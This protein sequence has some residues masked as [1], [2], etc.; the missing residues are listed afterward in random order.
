MR[1]E[2][3]EMLKFQIKKGLHIAPG[4]SY[5]S[6]PAFNQFLAEALYFKEFKLIEEIIEKHSNELEPGIRND[7]RNWGLASLFFERREY[8]KALS[9]AHK[10]NFK[11]PNFRIQ[12]KF[13]LFR[14]F[15]ELNLTEQAISV[16]NIFLHTL[17]LEDISS[18]VK[19]R[20]ELTFKNSLRFLKVF[21]N[22]IE[23]EKEF[24]V[25]KIQKQN[26]IGKKWMMEKINSLKSKN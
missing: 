19:A 1:K 21:N 25:N 7:M 8:E 3:F 20:Y 10:I 23:E 16:I 14:I 11:E 22:E 6:T 15:F 4:S 5:Y 13:L 26:F 18:E 17:K 24:F 9:F 12:S 2:S